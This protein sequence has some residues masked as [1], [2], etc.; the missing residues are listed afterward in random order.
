MPKLMF[1]IIMVA[2]FAA[3]HKGKVQAKKRL[4]ITNSSLPLSW[5]R[6]KAPNNRTPTTPSENYSTS[7]SPLEEKSSIH[8]IN[9]ANTQSS[10]NFSGIQGRGSRRRLSVG[11]YSHGNTSILHVH[12]I[13]QREAESALVCEVG[14]VLRRNVGRV[15]D[16]CVHTERS[17]G[18]RGHVSQGQFTCPQR[19]NWT[20]P[21]HNPDLDVKSLRSGGELNRDEQRYGPP[22]TLVARQPF[23]VMPRDGRAAG[24]TEP[25]EL[26]S[27]D[28]RLR[29]ISSSDNSSLF[30]TATNS[31]GSRREPRTAIGEPCRAAY[32]FEPDE[33]ASVAKQRLVKEWKKASSQVC[34]GCMFCCCLVCT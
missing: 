15:G 28:S 32:W 10:T 23:C 29:P 24:A 3:I 34:L 12:N 33:R 9:E 4:V 6:T 14:S 16:V 8:N 31:S 27:V 1:I 19:T 13:F 11:N 26:N 7:L 22:C 17:R 18:V 30:T 20:G 21:S 2:F 5:S 25:E